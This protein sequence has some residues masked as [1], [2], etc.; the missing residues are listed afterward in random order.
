[1]PLRE[2][3]LNEYLAK[4]ALE[5]ILDKSY[6]PIMISCTFGVNLTGVIIGCLR[7]IQNWN[8]N[9][10]LCEYILY[11]GEKCR[12]TN[13][14]FIE[15]FDI[16]L[17]NLPS[18]LPDFMITEIQLMEK[19]VQEFEELKNKNG[20]KTLTNHGTLKEILTE[21]EDVP[22][23]QV[24]YYCNDGPLASIRSKYSKLS[25]IKEEI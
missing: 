24:Y 14:E 10:I 6:H 23:Y 15:L 25:L 13:E 19:E 16:D 7:K 9:S 12:Y 21:K 2:K 11:S 22:A 1:M 8:L 18:N 20:I 3:H 5:I 17:V 4:E